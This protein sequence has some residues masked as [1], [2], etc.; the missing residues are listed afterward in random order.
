MNLDNALFI[1]VDKSFVWGIVIYL[2]L[3]LVCYCLLG[4]KNE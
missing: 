4:G 2:F 1:R 3:G